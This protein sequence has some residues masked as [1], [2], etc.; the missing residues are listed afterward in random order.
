MNV[1]LNNKLNGSKENNQT[2]QKNARL[3]AWCV[4]CTWNGPVQVFVN[5]KQPANKKRER[6]ILFLLLS[7]SLPFK[8]EQKHTT[9]LIFSPFRF[10]FLFCIYKTIE[11]VYCWAFQR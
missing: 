6:K 3:H 8:Q 7:L 1:F 5:P 4:M 10:S 11:R 2:K 9:A